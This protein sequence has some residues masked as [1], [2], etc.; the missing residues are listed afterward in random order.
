[1]FAKML[2]KAALLAS[3]AISATNAIAT[4]S[5]TGNKFFD[6]DGNQFFIKGKPSGSR[7]RTLLISEL[8][9]AYQ[10][11]DNDPLIDADQCQRDVSLMKALGANTIR[12]YHVDSTGDHDGCMSAFSDAGIYLLVDLDTF[13]TAINPVKLL[14]PS[15]IIAM[16]DKSRLLPHGTKRSSAATQPSWTHSQNT[17]TQWVS[18]SVTKS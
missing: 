5:T 6:S 16:A 14:P 15:S 11:T 12:V 4:I 2:V 18:S 8:G 1:M 10:L 7:M 3:F 13:T 9:V 17:T